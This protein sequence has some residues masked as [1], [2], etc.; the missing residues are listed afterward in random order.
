MGLFGKTE[1]QK[2]QEDL[3]KSAK[4]NAK[5]NKKERFQD[6]RQRVEQYKPM[7]DKEGVI[8]FKN[9]FIAILQRKFGFQVEFIIAFEDLTKE[10]YEL[11]AIDEGK[12]GGQASGG[13]TGGVNS[14]YYFQKKEYL[15]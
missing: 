10:G 7:W 6:L 11:K 1:D 13:F 14:Y 8:Q 2:H 3:E 15:K 9:E 5:E 4:E 12:S